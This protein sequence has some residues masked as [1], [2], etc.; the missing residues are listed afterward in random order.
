MTSIRW[1]SLFV[2]LLAAGAQ[3]PQVGGDYSGTLG[4]LHLK[5]HLNVSALI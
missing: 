2:C 4:P 1:L 5:L 3:A